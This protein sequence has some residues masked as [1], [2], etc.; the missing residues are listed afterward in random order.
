MAEAW[1]MGGAEILGRARENSQARAGEAIH[2]HDDASGTTWH[3]DAGD[4]HGA[5]RL[6]LPGFLASFAG[7]VD[8]RPVAVVP[9]RGHLH[10]GGDRSAAMVLWLAAKGR[11]AFQESPASLSPALYTTGDDDRPVPYHP[12]G[13]GRVANEVRLGHLLLASREYAAR[14]ADLQRAVG[15]EGLVAG[16]ELALRQAD[17]RPFAWTTYAEGIACYL[18]PAE[19]VA[20]GAPG[21]PPAGW[22]TLDALEAAAGTRFRRVVLG[23]LEYVDAR[24]PLA[25]DAL[26]ALRARLSPEPAL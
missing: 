5:G 6:V 2:R 20:V 26:A 10:V 18:P 9:E 15:R 17:G 22:T 16:M 11:T 14:T 23:G 25:A 7:K 19:A 13:D 1:G 8:G 4:L 3:V 21:G 24:Q 12:P